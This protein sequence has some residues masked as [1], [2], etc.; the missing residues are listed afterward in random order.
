MKKL[1][2][3][4]EDLDLMLSLEI[5]EKDKEL[6]QYKNNWEELKKMFEADEHFEDGCYCGEILNKMKELEE[7]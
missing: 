1:I 5:E 7:E 3:S 2:Y 6:D 4:Q